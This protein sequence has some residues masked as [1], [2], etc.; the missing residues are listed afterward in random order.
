M[1]WESKRHLKNRMDDLE[2]YNRRLRCEVME[3]QGKLEMECNDTRWLS[4]RIDALE[5][6]LLCQTRALKV[7]AG[8]GNYNLGWN[9]ALGNVERLI[10]GMFGDCSR[11]E[12]AT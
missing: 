4:G 1:L 7:E 8:T 5:R 11:T 2:R 10:R 12:V 3:L 6:N 9:H